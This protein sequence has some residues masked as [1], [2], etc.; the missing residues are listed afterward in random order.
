MWLVRGS[1]LTLAI[2]RQV[3]TSCLV[4]TTRPH[5]EKGPYENEVRFLCITSSKIQILVS[6]QFFILGVLA[7]TQMMQQQQKKGSFYNWSP[8]NFFQQAT[9]C[10]SNFEHT[11]TPRANTGNKHVLPTCAAK[12]VRKR[13]LRMS[14]RSPIERMQKDVHKPSTNTANATNT[15]NSPNLVCGAHYTVGWAWLMREGK[16][17]TLRGA[18]QALHLGGPGGVKKASVGASHFHSVASASPSTVIKDRPSS[19]SGWFWCRSCPPL[20]LPHQGSSEGSQLVPRRVRN[21]PASM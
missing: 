19:R 10:C 1:L 7:G 21:V 3:A 18:S 6:M 4:M 9:K 8:L 5:I 14:K 13:F 12:L 2:A 20:P 15:A 11:D 17:G 16:G